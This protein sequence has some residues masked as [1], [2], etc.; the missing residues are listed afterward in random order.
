M[1]PSSTTPNVLLFTSRSAG[2]Q[3]G[4]NFDGW[5]P[6]GTFHYTGE[7]QRGDQA[8]THG[9]RAVQD[10]LANGRALR[11]FEKDDT[12][13]T[14]VGE[15][16]VPD[17]SYVLKDEA[18][19]V[20]HQELRSVYV[21]RLRPV[22]EVLRDPGMTAPSVELFESVPIEAS[23]VDRY[24]LERA[25]SEPG[26]GL[27][28][29]AELVRR[30]VQWLDRHRGL[31]VERQKIPTAAGHLMFTDIYVRETRDLI[32]AKSSIS[33][34]HIRLALGQI[35]DYARYVDHTTLAVLTP[36]QPADEMIALLIANGVGC[37]W[38]A[39]KD[40]FESRRP[41]A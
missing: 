41:E 29:E 38:E 21:F 2:E 15:F 37:I 10:H 30:Y 33:R 39:G 26:V 18:P 40:K 9:N 16:E 14:Y 36:S 19:D 12:D 24:V 11:L 25:E 32:E 4:Y 31:T 23:N 27:R 17:E 28:T 22:G 20:D 34:E 3:F 35:L 13:V 1:E 5:H 6:D 8:M 7:G